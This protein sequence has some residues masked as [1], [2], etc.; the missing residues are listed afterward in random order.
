MSAVVVSIVV[1]VA[2]VVAVVVAAAV[3]VIMIR[4]LAIAR[5]PPTP[6]L[7]LSS[8]LLEPMCRLHPLLRLTPSCCCSCFMII[9]LTTRYTGMRPGGPYLVLGPSPSELSPLYKP[10]MREQ[11]HVVLL[12]QEPPR[13]SPRNASADPPH[14]LV[15]VPRIEE[16]Q[17]RQ[18]VRTFWQCL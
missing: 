2:G 9:P 13:L 4:A 18:I 12:A 7:L 3:A 5:L 15:G 17:C 6:L 11:R 14:I 8:L 10:T 16:C 1:A